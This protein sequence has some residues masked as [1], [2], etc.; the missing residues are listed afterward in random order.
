MRIISQYVVDGVWQHRDDENHEWDSSNV[1]NVLYS[2]SRSGFLRACGADQTALAASAPQLAV[3]SIS[4]SIP[5]PELVDTKDVLLIECH[6]EALRP[7][8]GE[9]WWLL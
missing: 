4:R 9:P 5:L 8:A 3:P 2:Q 7:L 1:N 6:N